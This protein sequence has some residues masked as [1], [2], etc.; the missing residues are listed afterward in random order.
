MAVSAGSWE[1]APLAPVHCAPKVSPEEVAH[2]HP[3]QTRMCRF[4]ASGSLWQSLARS[5]VT[6]DNSCGRRFGYPLWI[7]VGMPENS[8]PDR[9]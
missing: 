9:N 3:S 1:S 6:M 7:H 8:D 2:P 5:G 4:P